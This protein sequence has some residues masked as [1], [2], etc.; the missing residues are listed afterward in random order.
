MVDDNAPFWKTK[1][2]EEM[3]QAE[4]E[5]LCDGCARCCLA[6]LEDEDSG[7]IVYTEIGCRLLDVE[8]CRCT[9]YP[10]RSDHVSDCVRLTADIIRSLT[11]LPRT[12][13]YRLVILGRDL[14]WWHPLVS[15]DP[16]SVHAAGVSVRGRVP[17]LDDRIAVED[18]ENF[19]VDWPQRLPRRA[20]RRLPAKTDVTAPSRSGRKAKPQRQT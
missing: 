4:W 7:R 15:G 16:Q 6:K 11:W 19:L 5:S 13:A 18:L 10:N 3:S 17:F 9:D 12:C 2:I 8:T 20:Q 1:P 14:Y